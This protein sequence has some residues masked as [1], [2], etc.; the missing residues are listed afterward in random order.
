MEG[1]DSAAGGLPKRTAPG[2]TSASDTSRVASACAAA[3]FPATV[4]ALLVLA[5]TVV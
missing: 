1:S 5:R 2:G 4:A 3:R